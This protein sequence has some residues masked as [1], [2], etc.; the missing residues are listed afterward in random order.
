MI[1][2]AESGISVKIFSLNL[3][4]RY[5]RNC[6]KIIRIYEKHKVGSIYKLFKYVML[7]YYPTRTSWN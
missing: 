7:Y 6:N 3:H 4:R 1:G 2:L 5:I